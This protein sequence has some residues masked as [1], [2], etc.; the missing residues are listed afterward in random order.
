KTW[1]EDDFAQYGLKPRM[2]GRNMSYNRETATLRGMHFQRA[3]HAETKL[4]SVLAG[5]IW[6]VAVDVRHDSPTRGKWVG[7]ELRA[8][9]G[10]M[11]YIPEGFAHGYITLEPHTTVE[12]MIS[13]FYAPQAADGVRWD[14]PLFGIEWPAEPRILSARDR[15]WPDFEPSMARARTRAETV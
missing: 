8:E 7:R 15:S 4:V 3:P 11:L 1:G 2:V 6:D 14:D 13:E 12:Y 10:E 5:S 9:T